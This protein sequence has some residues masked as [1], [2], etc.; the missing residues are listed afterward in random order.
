MKICDLFGLHNV[1]IE[2]WW[3]MNACFL[4]LKCHGVCSPRRRILPGK[5][6]PP[7]LAPTAEDVGFR[8]KLLQFFPRKVIP[9]SL[10][11]IAQ[12]VGFARTSSVLDRAS[13]RTGFVPKPS[14][15]GSLEGNQLRQDFRD[16][17]SLWASTMHHLKQKA[18]LF[19]PS[20]APS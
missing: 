9:P 5:V 6:I 1:N 17:H 10:A 8:P 3:R 18:Y 14:G 4:N 12:D 11:P 7:S 2:E 20:K 13:E 15:S 16:L 19:P